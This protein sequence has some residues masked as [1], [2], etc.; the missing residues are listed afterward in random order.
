MPRHGGK[1]NVAFVDGHVALVNPSEID[2]GS[3]DTSRSYVGF[4]HF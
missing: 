3:R 4:G 1:I 2:W